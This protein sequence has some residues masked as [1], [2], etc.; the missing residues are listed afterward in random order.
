MNIRLLCLALLAL[1]T[2]AWAD[3]GVT[4]PGD[5]PHSVLVDFGDQPPTPGDQFDLQ[6]DGQCLATAKVYR[7]QPHRVTLVLISGITYTPQAGDVVVPS[8]HPAPEQTWQPS[9]PPPMTPRP[10]TPQYAAYKQKAV[11]VVHALGAF[12]NALPDTALNNN[13]GQIFSAM[14]QRYAPYHQALERVLPDIQGFNG[15]PWDTSLYSYQ[16]IRD[17]EGDL[18]Q[19]DHLWSDYVDQA[20]QREH[21]LQLAAQMQVQ[22]NID[23]CQAK[24]SNCQSAMES[25]VNAM[26]NQVDKLKADWEYA[27]EAL[28][29]NN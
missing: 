13:E 12:R 23:D 11:A 17:T 25:D 21:W 16:K 29:K 26:R 6:R 10:M 8:A 14:V 22:D 24:A 7:I 15:G 9:P 4:G 18:D 27:Q 20:S 28:D 3:P 2:W 1:S 5:M 19:M